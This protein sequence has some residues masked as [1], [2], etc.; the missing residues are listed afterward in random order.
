MELQFQTVQNPF[1]S[2]DWSEEQRDN[3]LYQT[4]K[5]L[6]HTKPPTS[7]HF[8]VFKV[9]QKHAKEENLPLQLSSIK[10]RLTLSQ[11]FAIL[12][13][14]SHAFEQKLFQKYCMSRES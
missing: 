8:E 2:S 7:L 9:L 14:K 11:D 13:Q 4:I 3:V 1:K 10:I 12:K 6:P 5:I